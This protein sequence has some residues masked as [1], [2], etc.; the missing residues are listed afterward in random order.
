MKPNSIKTAFKNSLVYSLGNISSKLIGLVLVP[1]YT[2][3]LSVADYGLLGI[4]EITAQ[5]LVA[6]F[7]F[8]LYAAFFRWYW[9]KEIQ[10]RQKSLFFTTLICTIGFSIVMFT[11]VYCNA[12]RLAT[13]LFDHNA[14]RSLIVFMAFSAALQIVIELLSALLRIQERAILF[15]V[16]NIFKL[17]ISLGFTIYYVAYARQGIMG[18]YQAQII[19]Q[20]CLIAI[21]FRYTLLNIHVRFEYKALTAMLSFAAPL[22]LAS[23]SAV[24]LNVADRYCLKFLGQL[25]YVGIYALGY[26]IA[27]TIKIFVVN[28]LGLAVQPTLYRVLDDS[29]HQSYYARMMTYIALAVMLCVLFFSVFGKEIIKFLAQ[30]REYWDSFRIIP[31]ISVAILFGALRDMA[32]IG[33]NI[34]KRT[35]LIATVIIAMSLMNIGL[36]ILLIPILE[37]VGAAVAMLIT[38]IIYF[39][40]ILALAQKYYPVP[41]EYKRLLTLFFVGMAL[42]GISTVFADSSLLVRLIAKTTLLVLYAPILGLI[43]FLNPAERKFIRRKLRLT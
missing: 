32:V 40:I 21:L 24:L 28:S 22:M 17:V 43:G 1:L 37:Y 19:G 9:D 36:N 7:G 25:S 33:L 30:K 31:I 12:A 14:Y 6:F 2:E 8:N 11:A 20:L 41:Y 13:I 5:V 3:H 39:A 26:K 18:I 38:Q 23:V 16:S 4:L 27:N 42:F 15:A 34:T 10:G 29:D 35:G